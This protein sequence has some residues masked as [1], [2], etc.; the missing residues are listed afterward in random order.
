MKKK[1]TCTDIITCPYILFVT[2]NYIHFVV[3][4][5]DSTYEFFEHHN[6]KNR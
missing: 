5:L 3:L 1:H 6:Y 2:F 4:R